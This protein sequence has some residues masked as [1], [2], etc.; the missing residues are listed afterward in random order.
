MVTLYLRLVLRAPVSKGSKDNELDLHRTK[1]SLNVPLL[2]QASQ[3][4]VKAI[5]WLLVLFKLNILVK[6]PLLLQVNQVKLNVLERA[7]LLWLKEVKFSVL[8]RASVHHGKA[9]LNVQLR[10]A[11]VHRPN[12]NVPK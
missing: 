4:M 12:L 5:R 8:G 7:Q 10:C 1:A 9:N 6:R 3:I 2:V 11:P